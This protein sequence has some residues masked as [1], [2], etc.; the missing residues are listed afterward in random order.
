[1]VKAMSTVT[2]ELRPRDEQT[3][4]N[5]RRWEEVLADPALS[6][7]EGRVETDRHGRIIMSP[8]PAP[9]HGE[10]QVQ[11]AILL[12]A[13]MP[14]GKTM[15]ESPASAADGVRAV[16]VAWSSPERR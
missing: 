10:F 7:I 1:M 4:F 5:L 8:T 14:H 6:K 12:R 13:L 9:R 16:D 15:T 2:L 11:I 3:A